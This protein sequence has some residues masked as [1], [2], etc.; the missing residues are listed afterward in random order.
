MV[1][2]HIYAAGAALAAIW[3]ILSTTSTF[4]VAADAAYAAIVQ[5]SNGAPRAARLVPTEAAAINFATL[6]A[7][8]DE[9]AT[10]RSA[11]GRRR[12]VPLRKGPESLAAGQPQRLAALEPPRA[13]L[14]VLAPSPSPAA[15]YAAVDDDDT[16]IPPDT[17]GA[18]GPNIVMTTLNSTYRVQAKSTGAIL[19]SVPITTFWSAVHSVDVFDPRILYDPYQRRFVVSAASD[20]ESPLSSILIGISDTSDPTGSWKLFRFQVCA[21]V[22]CGATGSAFSADF[23]VLGLNQNWVAVSANMFSV[24]T[25]TFAESRMMVLNYP[26]LLAGSATGMLLTEL[27]DFSITPVMTYSPTEQ[28]L[29][30]PVHVESDTA[31]YR[32]NTL[33]GTPSEPVYTR[34]GLLIHSLVS[35]WALPPPAPQP[36]PPALGGVVDIDTG[37][38]RI[39]NAVFRN[40]SIWYSQ[41]IGLPGPAP[42]HTAAQWVRLNTL[43]AD[44]DAGRVEDPSATSTNGIWYAYPS[45]AVNALD[46]VMLGFTHFSAAQFASAAYAFRSGNA[47][48]GVFRAPAISKLGEGFYWKTFNG[49]D[50]RWGDYSTTQVDP[51]DDLSFWTIQEFA[52]RPFGAGVDSGRWGTWWTKLAAASLGTPND[53]NGDT[54]AD[55]VWRNYTTGAAEIWH[56][57]GQTRLD[58]TPLPTVSDVNWQLVAMADFNADGRTDLV[59]RNAATGDNALWYMNGASVL[60]TV[61]LPVVPDLNWELV[62]AVDMNRDGH[63]DL[64]WRNVRTGTNVV[65]YLNGTVL[66]ATASLPT[67]ADRHWQLAGAA[68]LN[69]DGMPDLLWRNYG[70]GVNVVWFMNGVTIAASAALPVVPDVSWQL[71]GAVDINADGRPDLIWRNPLTGVNIAWFM[72]GATIV[73][74]V[75]LPVL[76]DSSWKFV[77]AVLVPGPHD[78]N[79]D[80]HADILW[81]NTV[82]GANVVWYM[83]GASQLDAALLPTMADPAWQIATTGDFNGDGK[84]D[85]V[86]RNTS[87]GENVL[88]YMNGKAI[89]SS[90]MLP[91]VPD[92][93]WH[94]VTAADI[95]GDGQADL[96]WRNASLATTVVW[97]MTGGTL[98]GTATLPAVSDP[99]WDLAAAADMNGDGLIDLIWRN[100]SSGV[101][102]VWYMNG[103]LLIG[104]AALP[105]VTD[106]AWQLA[107]A[108]DMNGDGQTDLVWRNPASAANVL[109]TMSGVR[110]TG[111]AAL[112]S[113]PGSEWHIVR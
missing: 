70:S 23:P 81:R 53:F 2:P 8:S 22:I 61:N 58:T 90:A 97:Y 73:D 51:D 56:M 108:A 59:W 14:G 46:D 12:A 95:N 104:A 107:M 55:L 3:M 29:Y 31:E 44:V 85:L 72:S 1:R 84:P 54:L 67:V 30:M 11:A 16:A 68:D 69:A 65:W 89:G 102:V 71:V 5:S 18:V 80:M 100:T 74:S 48:A 94:L 13:R 82:T 20:A 57:N 43:G 96:V 79:G 41:S 47:A 21:I 4:S 33:T 9:R 111:A 32:L 15:M 37:D 60:T 62:S 93:A 50:N 17:Q 7:R 63:P 101:N 6:A 110:I 66:I 99:A 49:P 28:T 42:T 105:P 91:T 87:T 38:A 39:I 86:W 98:T 109:W 64:I 76:P 26:N 24:F 77:Q 78:V 19:S 75:V 10:A 113:V 35:P 36:T 92:Q 34:G 45:I 25:G 52:R 40:G 83:N 112:P 88:W 27:Q 106:T 103:A